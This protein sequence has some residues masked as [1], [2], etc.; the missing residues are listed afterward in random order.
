MKR[1]LFFIC[2]GLFL[3]TLFLCGCQKEQEL[4]AEP[5]PEW[6]TQYNLGVR[7][8][9]DGNYEEAILAFEAAIEIDPG[10]DRAYAK[11]AETYMELGD[12]ET[13]REILEDA[14]DEMGDSS[15]LKQ[16]L[17]ELEAVEAAPPEVSVTDAFQD[18]LYDPR[19]NLINCYHIP[20]VL[21]DGQPAEALNETMYQEL[22]SFLSENVYAT[23]LEIGAPSFT[24]MRY[25]YGQNDQIGSILLYHCGQLEALN[26]YSF[27]YFSLETGDQ[28]SVPQVLAALELTEAEFYELAQARMHH[29]FLSMKAHSWSP[30]VESSFEKIEDYEA[31]TLAEDNVRAAVPFFDENGEL[32]ILTTIH[33]P[34][35]GNG[36]YRC[37]LYLYDDSICPDPTCTLD[38][39][40]DVEK[41]D[42]WD[43]TLEG[44]WA[45]SEYPTQ[46][47]VLI[48][49][50]GDN[51]YTVTIEAIRGQGAQIATA[52]IDDFAIGKNGIGFAQ[53]QDSFGNTGWVYLDKYLDQMTLSYNT[54]QPYVGG[55]CVDIG[56]GIY[57]KEE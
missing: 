12:Y 5:E 44:R 24:S 22:F 32:C 49:H 43:T 27:Y 57:V 31:R 23:Y 28:L 50:N 11:L 1:T 18:C 21:I 33:F 16:T 47:S 56:A 54:D 29:Q 41:P 37:L 14:M 9:R 39:N 7:Y 35:G 19:F 42:G 17:E 13:A 10:Q 48:E 45:H 38:H 25:L 40:D 15:R 3:L 20:Q 36:E 34:G 26:T 2:A 51:T 53:Y 55:W 52:V 8:L 46:Y 30:E 6:K 4:P